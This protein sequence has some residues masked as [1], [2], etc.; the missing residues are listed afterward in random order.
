MELRTS[1]VNIASLLPLAGVRKRF[2]AEVVLDT[3]LL[4]QGAIIKCAGLLQQAGYCHRGAD[5]INVRRSLRGLGPHV[6]R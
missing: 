4:L 1:L 3:R 6:R 2:I 5:T